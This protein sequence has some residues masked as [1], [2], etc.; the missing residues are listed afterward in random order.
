MAILSVGDSIC[1]RRLFFTEHQKV[2]EKSCYIFKHWNDIIKG[3]FTM[4]RKK[5]LRFE[6]PTIECQILLL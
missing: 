1:I 4:R 6:I 3:C 2:Y 5:I